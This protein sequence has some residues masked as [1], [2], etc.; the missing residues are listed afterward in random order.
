MGESVGLLLITDETSA[1]GAAVL[2]ERVGFGNAGF[3]GEEKG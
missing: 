3:T 2:G 1:L